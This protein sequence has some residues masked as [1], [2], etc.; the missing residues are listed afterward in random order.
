MRKLLCCMLLVIG[1]CV[2]FNVPPASR[3]IPKHMY[4]SVGYVF[5]DRG[6]GPLIMFG[7]Y[8]NV[9]ERE[10]RYLFKQEFPD[11]TIVIVEKF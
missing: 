8:N 7:T 5:T 3:E 2:S 11:E 10:A 4:V 9:S 1:G 6:A